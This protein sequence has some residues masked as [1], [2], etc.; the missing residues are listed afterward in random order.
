MVLAAAPPFHCNLPWI[1]LTHSA[2]KCRA[3]SEGDRPMNDRAERDSTAVADNEAL[4]AQLRSVDQQ[5]RDLRAEIG[6]LRAA[7]ADAVAAS[8]AAALREQL[9]TVGAELA[10]SRREAGALRDQAVAV[11]K[12][13]TAANA[14][15]SARERSDLERK[16][17]RLPAIISR[18]DRTIEDFF[19][20][21]SYGAMIAE[22]EERCRRRPGDV[23]AR[24]ELAGAHLWG[25]TAWKGVMRRIP[26]GSDPDAALRAAEDAV[27][28][29]P[30]LP[31][32]R[33][34]LRTARGRATP[35]MIVT[36]LPRSGSVSVM[37]S[38]AQGLDKTTGGGSGGTFP[39]LV[40][41]HRMFY[42][43]LRL[44]SAVHAHWA[45]SRM[46]LLEIGVRF[47]V[48]RMQVH[49]RDPRQVMISWFHFFPHVARD[50]DPVQALH[51]RA[52]DDYFERSTERQL[53]WLIDNWLH[54]TIDWIEGWVQAEREPWFKT[55]ILFTTFEDMAADP[56][57]FFDR[58]LDFYGVERDL[59]V[60]PSKPEYQGDRNFRRGE[61]DEWRR[62][63]T[64]DQQKR[65][66][67]LIPLS[68]YHR[69]GWPES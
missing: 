49:V 38:L 67:S 12:E 14:T 35:P 13:L 47:K 59:F 21:A 48:D 32:A 61:V 51:H 8:E 2:A 17:R 39:N 46:N 34:L 42:L 68:L 62:V 53:D 64:S 55:K 23:R 54:W 60:Q 41:C 24:M 52:P 45:P 19:D 6:R 63:L 7:Y 27:R 43:A 15:I 1:M 3:A 25:T 9:R 5:C 18:L 22:L 36:A 69:F 31:E 4:R 40:V 58:I 30:D 29:A 44:R 50:L 16:R 57:A 11:G 10:A 37:N 20:P 56:R 66:S 33:R 65:A 28:I 26:N